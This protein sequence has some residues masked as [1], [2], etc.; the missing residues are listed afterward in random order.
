[1]S[2]MYQGCDDA[3]RGLETSLYPFKWADAQRLAQSPDLS[4][5]HRILPF[6]ER[7]RMIYIELGG[8]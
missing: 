5:N 4:E 2:E 1:M 7:V 8:E 6:W 3:K